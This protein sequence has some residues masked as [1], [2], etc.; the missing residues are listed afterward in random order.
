MLQTIRERFTGAFA[1]AIIAT[2]AVALTITLVDTDTFTGSANFAARVNGEQIAIADFRQVAQQQLLEQEEILRAELTPEARQQIE[3]NV[4]EGLV[5]NRV[6]AQYVRE[7][8]YRISDARLADH[9]RGLPAFQVAGKFSADGYAAAL[10]SQGVSV[11]TFQEEQRAALQIQQLQDGLLES[12]FFTPAEFRRFV[13]LEGEQRRVSFA[14]LDPS[15]LLASVPVAEADLKAWYDGHP[16]DF[17]SVESVALE[18]VE[19]K[20]ADFGSSAPTEADLRAA[21]DAAPERFVA[22]EQ[23]RA[24]HILVAI[25]QDTDDA[26]AASLAAELRKRLDA[27]EDFAELARQYS[28]DPGSAQSGGD[29]GWAGSGT[30]VAPFERALFAQAAGEISAPVKTEFGYHIIQ[31]QELRAGARKS[32]EDVRDELL[33]EATARGSQDQFYALTEKMDD[34]ALE[35]PGSLAPVALAADRPVQR[36]ETF[37]RAGEGPFAGNRRVIDAAFSAALLEDGENS[38]LIEAAEGHAVILRVAQHRPV[39]LRPFAE[40]RAEVEA[41]YRRGRAAELVKERG[42]ALL[43]KARGGA[44]FSLA[45]AEAGATLVAPSQVLARGATEAPA[46]LVA[47]IF[48]TTRP[49]PG[50][51]T[52]DGLSLADDRYAAFRLEEVVPGDPAAIPREQRDARKG[53]LGRQTAVS[54]VTGLAAELREAADVVIAPTLFEQPDSL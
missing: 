50:K 41:G 11:E 18:Y 52:Y 38:A 48:R 34:A 7:E 5:R 20:L 36:I 14:I 19:V 30:Y 27:G 39:K 10:A 32:F 22:V 17:E 3:R 35:S 25:D 1:I 37:T 15:L 26:K 43:E 8:G 40:V 12:S 6:V 51:S 24:R 2:I 45:A 33:R 47:R 31:L 46:D 4:L 29:L 44:D 13:L 28:D 21:Y 53:L 49:A 42:E 9:I 23:R 16:K 54:E